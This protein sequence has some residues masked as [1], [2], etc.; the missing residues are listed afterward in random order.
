MKSTIKYF[1]CALFVLAAAVGCKKT[2]QGYL[3]DQIRYVDN[4]IRIGRG[5]IQQT[6]AVS[7]DGSSAPVTYKL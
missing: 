7:N 4:P 3:S 6:N 2:Q 5:L 1:G